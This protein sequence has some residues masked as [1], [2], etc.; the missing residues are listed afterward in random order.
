MF[1]LSTHVHTL[2]TPGVKSIIYCPPTNETC[3][4]STSLSPTYIIN[5]VVHRLLVLGPPHEC[6]R[7]LLA[8]TELCGPQTCLCPVRLTTTH[9]TVLGVVGQG[10]VNRL[11]N[12]SHGRQRNSTLTIGGRCW[13]N[14]VRSGVANEGIGQV[15]VWCIIG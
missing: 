15:A 2:V 12:A 1:T 13:G 6:W 10:V 9:R 3:T 7:L 14:T 4:Q 8:A 5:V 11:G